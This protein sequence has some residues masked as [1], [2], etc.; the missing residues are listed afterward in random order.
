MIIDFRHASRIAEEVEERAK[1]AQ[2][3]VYLT[4]EE[5]RKQEEERRAGQ[6]CIAAFASFP[7]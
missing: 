4:I 6:F 5:I 3:N 2:G 7:E 1:D